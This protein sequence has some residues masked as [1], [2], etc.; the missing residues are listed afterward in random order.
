MNH[1]RRFRR[2]YIADFPH[3]P[4]QRRQL[5]VEWVPLGVGE[6]PGWTASLVRDGQR[7]KEIRPLAVFFPWQQCRCG[8][9]ASAPSAPGH[10]SYGLHF[11]VVIPGHFRT[12]RRAPR[13]QGHH[14]GHLS[15]RENEA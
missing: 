4:R 14:P 10:A 2:A 3:C 13:A 6:F 15:Q 9:R 7:A 12:S 8:Q 1:V 5:H 11:A